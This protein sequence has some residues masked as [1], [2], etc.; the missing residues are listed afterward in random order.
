MKLF[1]LILFTYISTASAIDISSAVKASQKAILQTPTIKTHK[2]NL[3]LY[4]I[5]KLPFD[6]TVLGTF[7]GLTLSLSKGQVN[8]APIKGMKLRTFG[9]KLR[10][11]VFYDLK[12]RDFSTSIK[13]EWSLK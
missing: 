12:S 7:A 13:I 10:P 4:L 1:I 6:K 3:E 8:T 11:D 5:K 2:K 9:G